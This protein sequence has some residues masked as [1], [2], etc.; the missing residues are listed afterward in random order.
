MEHQEFA[1]FM[2]KKASVAELQQFRELTFKQLDDLRNNLGSVVIQGGGGGGIGL[3]GSQGFMPLKDDHRQEE[4]AAVLEAERTVIFNRFELLYKQFNDLTQYCEKF[5]PRDEVE[6]AMH[7]IVVQVKLLK[8]NSV[9]MPVMR[10]ALKKKADA[11]D[12]KR[13]GLCALFG[14][15]LVTLML[16]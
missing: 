6:K 4:A 5:V 1:N 3:S 2:M 12:V 13:F 15:I 9:E 7:A 8:S 16:F 14:I 10:E 11:E